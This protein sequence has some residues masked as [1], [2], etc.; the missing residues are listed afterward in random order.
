[1]SLSNKTV[2]I[3]GANSGIGYEATLKLA[4]TGA[5]VLMACRSM[6]KAEKARSTILSQVPEGKIDILPVDVSE[7]SSVEDFVK[8][9]AEQIGELDILVNN[10]GIVTP[11]LSRNSMGH[12][13]HLATN[14]LGPFALTGRLLPY[15]NKRAPTRI[16]NIGSLA[17]RFG[18]F[19]FEDPNWDKT[20]FNHWKAYARSKIATASFTM[21]L[22]RRLQKNGADIISLGAHPGFAATDVG[23]KTGATTPKTAFGKWYQGKLESW[24]VALPVHAAE[25]M[26]HAISA[27]DVVGGDYYGPTGLFEIKGKTGK[28]RMNPLASDIEFGRRLWATSESL[29]GVRFLSGL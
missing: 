4:A 10:A 18:K 26:V 22:H 15:F 29:T 28:A 13:L 1:M 17:H 7:L 20:K 23:T 2:V 5:R 8:S 25:P 16:I 21:E 27:D 11:M 14:Y 3:T 9:F 24:I 19:D 6:D 12:E